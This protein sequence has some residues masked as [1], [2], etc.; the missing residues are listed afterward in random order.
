MN[1]ICKKFSPWQIT[2]GVC[3]LVYAG[4][5]LESILGLNCPEPLALLYSRSYYRATWL[6]TGLDA[7]FATAMNIRPKWLRDFLS[8]LFSVY[9]I[10]YANEA[11]EK[12]RLLTFTQRRSICIV[13]QIRIPIPL[14]LGT[15]N[16][17][18][19]WLFF[20]GS[21]LELSQ[22][23][24]LLLDIPGGGFICMSPQHH[25]ERLRGWAMRC[26]RPVLSLDYVKAP[27]YPYPH[28]INQCYYAYREI[29][30]S[31]G[32]V[33]GM[34]S[35]RKLNIIIS[36]DSAGAN[37]VAGVMF[38][39]LETQESITRPI[40]LVFAYP[41]LDFNLTSWMSPET[42]SIL[43]NEQSIINLSG[44]AQQKDHYTKEGPLA[45]VEGLRTMDPTLRVWRRCSKTS[46]D[47]ERDN[48]RRTAWSPDS[49]SK[50]AEEGSQINAQ[51][52]RNLEYCE[53][54][55]HDVSSEDTEERSRASIKTRLTMTSRAGYFQDRIISPGMM[56]AMAILYIGPNSNPDFATDYRISPIL[57]P[58]ELLA[59]FPPILITCGEKDPFVD[60]SV[61][62]SGRIREAKRLRKKELEEANFTHQTMTN[63]RWSQMDE[64]ILKGSNED[65]VTLAIIEGWSHGF[66]Q[67]SAI[68]P[69]AEGVIDWMGCW[70][71]DM[72]RKGRYTYGYGYGTVHTSETETDE[73]VV[74]VPKR[75]FDRAG[76]NEETSTEPRD[77]A[78]LTSKRSKHTA[79]LVSEAD[80]L[81]RRRQE[82]VFGIGNFRTGSP[83]YVQVVSTLYGH[84][85]KDRFFNDNF[86]SFPRSAMDQ[87]SNPYYYQ[88][89][90]T[91][92]DTYPSNA[93]HYDTLEHRPQQIQPQ[94]QPQQSWQQLPVQ[95]HT[96]T[97]PNFQQYPRQP[98]FS[99]QRPQGGL[100][101][102]VPQPQTEAAQS[103]TTQQSSR[104]HIQ[105]HS[106]GYPTPVQQ[107][108]YYPTRYVH[109]QPT[110][111]PHGSSTA[112]DLNS[113]SRTTRSSSS[114]SSANYSDPM[115]SYGDET[116][117]QQMQMSGVLSQTAGPSADP[118]GSSVVPRLPPIFQVERQ[119]VTTTATQNASAN[120]RRNDANFR[121]PVPGCGSTFTRRFNLKGHLRSHTSERPF[122]CEWPGCD[123]AFARQ[124]D[125]KRHYQLHSTKAG[126]HLCHG[127]GKSFSRPDALNRHRELQIFIINTQAFIER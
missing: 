120:R 83:G 54:Y 40:A 113:S 76:I 110:L 103:S 82:A 67:M 34:H 72:F 33:L 41:A 80:L 119:Q 115:S 9:Y 108:Q 97:Y 89:F 86:V 17:V 118:Y 93:D 70:I 84:T 52:I 92:P 23:S 32:R 10:I 35:A 11:E 102:A 49:F 61:I 47:L 59:Q 16:S 3:T 91:Q 29:V 51:S 6:V 53:K 43:R 15:Q 75:K 112:Y 8:I 65:W 14:S 125:C 37:L 124:H 5:N 74:F 105:S 71:E 45:V 57:A 117:A 64:Q 106:Y 25:E 95:T 98:Y 66:L 123:K 28:A 50:C 2:V 111:V 114:D 122:A 7:G 38:K 4:K 22:S 19:G 36:G 69:K 12:L 63:C 20:N 96:Y 107:E 78:L 18:T 27:E 55:I 79:G 58:S 21:E 73:G 13:R 100:L 26:R 116:Y 87:Q 104:S 77:K 109:S 127:C 85:K 30:S 48:K 31:K 101:Q 62:F 46:F 60:D 121:C 68:L 39:I 126:T 90:H 81:K 94:L 1:R 99:S 42:L 44:L 56:R 24:D 88:Q